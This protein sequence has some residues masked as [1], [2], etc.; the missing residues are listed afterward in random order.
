M[1]Q[2]PVFA[3]VFAR[4]SRFA[5]PSLGEHRHALVEGL[6]GRVVEIGAGT[7]A[8]FR[9]YPPEVDEL[10]AVE[11]EPY[12]RREAERAAR[13]AS[14]RVETVAGDAGRLPLADSAFDAAVVSLVLCSVPD[15]PRALA[16]IRRVLKPGGELRFWEHVAAP[17]GS[18]RRAA[19]TA[20]DLVWPRLFGGCHTGRDTLQAIEAAGF[21]I[22]RCRRFDLH[23]GPTK[24]HVLGTARAQDSAS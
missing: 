18:S 10:V 1:A 15:Q 13:N 12:L 11:P 22:E 23:R 8:S 20:A 2:H 9:H 17:K 5:E 16:E 4:L 19:Q 14:M 24:P 7:G 3:R 21:T 6:R